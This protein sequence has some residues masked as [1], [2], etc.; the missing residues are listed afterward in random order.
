MLLDR[1]ELNGVVSQLRD[2]RQ[3]V[4]RKLTESPNPRLLLSHADVRF[5]NAQSAR[6]FWNFILK[7]VRLGRIPIN[8]GIVIGSWILHHPPDVSRYAIRPRAVFADDMYLHPAAMNEATI[9]VGRQEKTPDAKGVAHHRAGPAIPKIEIANDAQLQRP[10]RPFAIPD[11]RRAQI[12]PA[13]ES[14]I[15]M[16]LADLP[17]QPARSFDPT[18]H[19]AKTLV[20]LRQL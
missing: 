15:M 2:A 5:V 3:N 13:I 18:Q 8:A 14:K 7:L 19:R 9:F 16:P 6:H 10:R 1:H 17:E 20:A 12:I 11:T 4:F